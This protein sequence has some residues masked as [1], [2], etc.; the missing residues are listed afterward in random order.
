MGIKMGSQAE[1]R[2]GLPGSDTG[3]R[4]RPAYA[5]KLAG[6]RLYAKCAP[7][8]PA[9]VSV[10]EKGTGADRFKTGAG[11]ATLPARRWRKPDAASLI[12]L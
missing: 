7:E 8:V 2:P 1:N 12:G 9:R 10:L 11:S 3:L 5:R 4:K 6:C